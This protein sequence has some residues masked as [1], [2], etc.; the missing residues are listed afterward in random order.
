MGMWEKDFFEKKRLV[1]FVKPS[2]LNREALGGRLPL[3]LQ[4]AGVLMSAD[5]FCLFIIIEDNTDRF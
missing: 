4:S 2:C 1:R 3:D 5:V